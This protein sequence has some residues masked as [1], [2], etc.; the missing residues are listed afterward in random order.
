MKR[1]YEVNETIFAADNGKLFEAKIIK[2][3]E[4]GDIFK[5]FIHYNGW[6]RKYDTWID[7]NLIAKKDDNKAIEKLREHAKSIWIPAAKKNKGSALK[8]GKSKQVVDIVEEPEAEDKA[9]SSSSSSAANPVE[10]VTLDRK[11]IRRA[12]LLKDIAEQEDCLYSSR[13]EI[14]FNLKT[15]LVDEWSLITKDCKRLLVLPKESS[16]TVRG[17]VEDFLESKA[18]KLGES[19]PVINEY[20]EL[21]AGLLTQF[22]KALPTILLYRQERDQYDALIKKFEKSTIDIYGAEHLIRFFMRLPKLLTGLVIPQGDAAK[23]IAKF[24]EFLKFISKE[25]DKY[26]NV[27]QYLTADE[28]MTHIQKMEISRSPRKRKRPSKYDDEDDE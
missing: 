21:L 24:V 3:Q 19:D 1:L 22:D 26:L 12:L 7:D 13:I 16:I 15:H 2:I 8:L 28:A 17:L 11:K 25:S 14:P 27:T 18:H 9:T 23:I 4:L 5:Y 6:A 10:G 20:K